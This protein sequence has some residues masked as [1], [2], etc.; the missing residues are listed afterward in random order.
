MMGKWYGEGGYEAGDSSNISQSS[1]VQ[2]HENEWAAIICC[3]VKWKWIISPSVLET[4]PRIRISTEASGNLFLTHKCITSSLLFL[5]A[6][7]FPSRYASLCFVSIHIQIE[8]H[9]LVEVN[10]IVL[11]L[12][13]RMSRRRFGSVRSANSLVYGD[14]TL[15]GS[16]SPLLKKH[17]PP[18]DS[19][20]V[21]SHSHF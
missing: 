21:S 18:L 6:C 20:E 11:N 14:R 1:E 17:H 4:K 9:L 15:E 5:N 2:T 19:P 13:V 3:L 10:K 7:T 12:Q 16:P 8:L